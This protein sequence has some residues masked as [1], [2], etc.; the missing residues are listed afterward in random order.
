MQWTEQ[1]LLREPDQQGRSKHPQPLSAA[2]HERGKTY[3]NYIV[4]SPT[5]YNTYQWDQR[6]DWNI[7]AKDQAYARYSSDHVI[8][9]SEPPLGP[10][11]DGSS[12]GGEYDINL[13][14]DFI[15]SK[16]HFFTPSFSNEFRFGFNADRFAFLQPNANV[17]LAPTLG[18][19]GIPFSPNEGGLPLGI[20]YG[21]SSWGSQGTSNESQNVY[22]I[23]DN[24][25]KT[26]GRHNFR[27]V[28]SFQSIRFFYRYAPSSLGN[29]YFTGLYTSDPAVSATTGAG[30]ADF[31]AD[32]MNISAL[33]T[34]PNINDS[35]WYNAG[36]I[37]DDWKLSPKLTLNLGVRYGHYEPTKENTGS[38]E[39][40]NFGNSR[41]R[42]RHSNTHHSDKDSE[43]A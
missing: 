19:G 40:F 26:V 8:A 16:T 42:H 32:H 15:L 29:D 33:S 24:V 35:F 43:Y 30:V 4:N 1:C 5:R 39:N 25:S 23:L 7:S 3:N 37:Q 41:Y 28:I 9:M 10:I 31:L 13:A 34:A 27:A 12:Y 2:E 17:D 6:L 14:Q 11:L 22:Q 36:Y 20:V 38:Q 18:P 21:L